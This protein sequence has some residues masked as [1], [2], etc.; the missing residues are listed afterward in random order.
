MKQNKIFQFEKLFFVPYTRMHVQ[1]YHEWM[2]DPE[3]LNATASEPLTLEEEY[4]NQISWAHDKDKYTF[5]L[6]VESDTL[7]GIKG[8]MIGDVNLFLQDGTAEIEIMIA[9]KSYHR[10]GYGW[11]GVKGMIYYGIK[12][13]NI[14]NFTCKIA[15]K[16]IGSQRLFH[17]LGFVE[18]S[19]SEY[20]HEVELHY[21]IKDTD[22]KYYNSLSI[23]D[24]E[25]T[26]N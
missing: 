18:V 4:L 14:Q 16:N 10:M 8:L 9:E 21:Q 22:R 2:S 1:K 19:R 6:E 25:F 7:T 15:Y 3:L 11:K 26:E 12:Y 24:E 13:L 17:K 23:H 5:I 20:F